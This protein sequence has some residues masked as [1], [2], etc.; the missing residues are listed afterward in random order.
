MLLHLVQDLQL[1]GV[2]VVGIVGVPT[3][4][5]S[6]VASTSSEET[7]STAVHGPQRPRGVN[8]LERVLVLLVVVGIRGT[9]SSVLAVVLV[10]VPS[11]LVGVAGP[12]CDLKLKLVTISETLGRGRKS[13]R[14]TLPKRSDLEKGW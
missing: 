5:A 9:T 1:T 4:L 11:I 14:L 10:H 2:A 8:Q 13:W 3:T 6:K 12:V 7:T